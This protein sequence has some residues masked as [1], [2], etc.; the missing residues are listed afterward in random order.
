M[1]GTAMFSAEDNHID[2][3]G[4]IRRH[5]HLLSWLVPQL[6]FPCL[7]EPPSLPAEGLAQRP[8]LYGL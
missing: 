4:V 8:L 3:F 1:P 6:G 5:L 7:F 2:A